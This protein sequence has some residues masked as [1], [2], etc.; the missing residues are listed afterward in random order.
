MQHLL[1]FHTP[2]VSRHLL[3]SPVFVMRWFTVA[4]LIACLSSTLFADHPD[5]ENYPVHPRIDLIGPLG[6]WLPPSYRRRY[7]RPSNIAGKISY[8]IAPSSLEAMS[9]HAS[10]HRNAYKDHK[11]RTV[12]H[13]FYPKPWDAI[14]IGSRVDTVNMTKIDKTPSALPAF[15]ADE[16]LQD[17]IRKEDGILE[18]LRQTPEEGASPSD[19]PLRPTDPN[20]ND[21]RQQL[22]EGDKIPQPIVAPNDKK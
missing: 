3:A 18:K 7:N 4:T 16:T 1:Q 5:K 13:Y 9:W 14:Q 6:N 20:S 11:P 19:Q 8:Y 2:A 17:V 15:Q 22:I 21:P 12:M 10:K